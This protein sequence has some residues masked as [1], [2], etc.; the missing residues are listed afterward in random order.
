MGTFGAPNAGF[1]QIS[2]FLV[3]KTPHPQHGDCGKSKGL[4]SQFL[5]KA[6]QLCAMLSLSCLLWLLVLEKDEQNTLL[7]TGREA[8]CLGGRSLMLIFTMSGNKYVYL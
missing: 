6:E 2:L 8:D 5:Q 4:H 3:N 7:Q 1:L